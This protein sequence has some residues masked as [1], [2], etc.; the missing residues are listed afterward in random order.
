MKLLQLNDLQRIGN[1]L[2]S[3]HRMRIVELLAMEAQGPGALSRT[4]EKSTTA[5][6]RQIKM[7]ED[8][9]LVTRTDIPNSVGRATIA[10]LN[11]EEIHRLVQEAQA[12]V[13]G[14]S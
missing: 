2:A 11:L 3:P 10:T 7:L 4:L 12:W 13:E 9:G 1:L 5:T 6:T 14:L 8:A